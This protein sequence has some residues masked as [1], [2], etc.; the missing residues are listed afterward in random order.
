[1]RIVRVLSG[2]QDIGISGLGLKASVCSEVRFKGPR[3]R[4]WGCGF[5][6]FGGLGF[7]G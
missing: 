2:L 5:R 7:G 4:V 1:M 6:G 3:L